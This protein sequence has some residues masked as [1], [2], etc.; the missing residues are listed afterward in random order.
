MLPLWC[1]VVTSM[2]PTR[3]NDLQRSATVEGAI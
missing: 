3:F 2:L 1:F